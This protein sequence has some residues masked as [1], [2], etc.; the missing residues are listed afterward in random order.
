MNGEIKNNFDKNGYVFVE[1]FFPTDL[2][3]DL[4]KH[5]FKLCNDGKTVKDDQCPLSDSVYGDPVFDELMK[6][7]APLVGGLVGI[8]LL[9]TYSYARIYRTGDELKPHVDRKS[10]EISMTATLGFE[11][12][13]VWEIFFNHN[14]KSNSLKIK[15]GDVAIYKGCEIPHWRNPFT[16]VWQVQLFLHYVD[17]KGKNSDFFMDKRSIM[18]EKPQIFSPPFM[19]PPNFN[20][21]EEIEYAWKDDVFTED[22]LKKIISLEKE[23]IFSDATTR[24][25]ATSDNSVRKTKVS[26]VQNN[27][28][29]HYIY[30]NLCQ[31]AVILNSIYFQFDLHGYYECL[32][33]SIYEGEGGHY[34][35]HY[36][37][38]MGFKAPPRKLT[39]ILMLSSNDEYEGGDLEIFNPEKPVKLSNV[40]GRVYV[41]PTYICHRVTPVTKGTRRTLVGWVCGNRFK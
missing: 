18:N 34:T 7:S 27:N 21:H 35:W 25:K 12:E 15:V 13:D 28:E 41:F 3:C 36:D 5:I 22:E 4:V 2:C 31:T 38:G 20:P 10:C 17:A 24:S 23:L 29:S 1:N 16:G 30:S 6:K 32:Q 37:M 40:F 11:A 9:P 33:Y 19:F 26:W 8:D 39:T 14:Q